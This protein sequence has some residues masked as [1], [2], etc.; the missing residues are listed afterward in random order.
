MSAHVIPTFHYILKHLQSQRQK[1]YGW[2]TRDGTT[3][4][5]AK[6]QN[7]VSR[8]QYSFNIM[9]T[10]NNH[11]MTKN[12]SLLKH[13]F[14]HK[15][16]NVSSWL[17]I[18]IATMVTACP[19]TPFNRGVQTLEETIIS[20]NSLIRENNPQVLLILCSCVEGITYKY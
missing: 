2:Y 6:F 8:Y 12:E 9:R 1:I 19:K 18:F 11:L 5:K 16:N 7:I 17:I 4:I 10:Q 13:C 20:R 3:G 15:I 14:G